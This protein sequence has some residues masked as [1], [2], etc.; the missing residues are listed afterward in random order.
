MKR[1]NLSIAFLVLWGTYNTSQAQHAGGIGSGC[2]L[3]IYNISPCPYVSN[4]NIY[5]GGVADGSATNSL[6]V[7][8]CPPV[9]NSNIYVGGSAAGYSKNILIVAVCPPIINTNI[10]VGGDGDGYA[11][12]EYIVS[13]C[14]PLPN[15]NIFVGGV[16]DGYA[17]NSLIITVCPPIPNSN[18]YYG[19][20]AD[21]YTTNSYI[22]SICPPISNTNIFTGGMNDGWAGRKIIQ[23][24]CPLSVLPIQLLFFDVTCKNNDRLFNWST[25]SETNND[26]FTIES[27]KDANVWKKVSSIT[28]AGNS[29]TRRDYSYLD[30]NSVI[31]AFYYRLKQTDFDGKFKYSNFIYNDCNE[32]LNVSFTIF[33]NPSNGKIKLSYN[34]APNTISKVNIYNSI[35]EMIYS[36]DDFQPLID[37]SNNPSGVYVIHLSSGTQSLTKKIILE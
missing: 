15:T 8:V 35:G 1:I 4:T 31:E 26:Y 16:A 2:S 23:T 29:P 18:I 33:P 7:T 30:L 9:S 32:V 3:S 19:G 24:V 34:G 22:A 25:A 5:Y 13:I 17:V 6:I 14:P 37:L 12:G 11:M 20:T 10:F 21:G 28:G 27:S 36:S